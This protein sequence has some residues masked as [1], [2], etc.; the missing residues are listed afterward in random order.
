MMKEANILI[1]YLKELTIERTLKRV[2]TNSVIHGEI[3]YNLQ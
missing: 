2:N 3:I 1:I